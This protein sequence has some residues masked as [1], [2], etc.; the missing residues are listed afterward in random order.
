MPNIRT[1]YDNLQIARTASDAV[2]RSAYRG[3]SQQHHPDKN[4]NDRKT[5][6]RRMKVINEAYAVLSD[7]VKR[8]EHDQWIT[9]MEGE[10]QTSQPDIRPSATATQV[11]YD[12]VVYPSR[13]K[14][15][16]M[17]LG[18][19]IFVAIG[20]GLF[21]ENKKESSWLHEVMR[22][23]AIYL[24]V[25]FFGFCGVFYFARL[26]N[27]SPSIVINE[28]GVQVMTFGGATLRWSEI[29][30]VR[31]E[32]YQKNRFL[33]IFPTNPEI[34]MKRQSLWGRAGTKFNASFMG[35]PPAIVIA[36]ALVGMPLE[37][38]I[39]EMTSRMPRA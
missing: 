29:A 11:A 20:V 22:S 25:P 33:A 1:H 26:I 18:S 27:P 37:K 4:P 19:I 16:W 32:E 10:T 9:Q 6:E 39:G 13:K 2:V 7:P 15:G 24:G 38:L 28:H 5:A 17:F 3:L 21:M 8:R 36:E 23:V 34:V 12:F 14:M 35:R 30:D 31:I